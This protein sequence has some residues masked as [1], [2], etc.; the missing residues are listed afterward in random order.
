MEEK[1][2]GKN[3]L[4][5]AFVVLLVF[6]LGIGGYFVYTKI[7]AGNKKDKGESSEKSVDNKNYELKKFSEYSH[8]LTNM[9]VSY[10]N[11]Y[12]LFNG[13]NR[14]YG[15][16]AF[17]AIKDNVIVKDIN[18]DVR[19]FD[20]TDIYYSF[21]NTP[22]PLISELKFVD[23]KNDGLSTEIYGKLEHVKNEKFIAKKDDKYGLI[24]KYGKEILSFE[25]QYIDNEPTDRYN[26]NKNNSYLFVIKNNKSGIVDIDGKV[27]I[28]LEYDF[29]YNEWYG[30]K[31]Y[32]MNDEY[33]SIFETNGHYYFM[34]RKNNKY[35]VLDSNNNKILESDKKIEYIKNIDKLIIAN[36]NNNNKIK[37][38]EFYSFDGKLIKSINIEE[39]W[40][41]ENY[42]N[43][44]ILAENNNSD[45]F[46]IIRN[47]T[48][49]NK[50]YLLD[51][52][53]N[54]KEFD[55]LYYEE[56]YGE[57]GPFYRYFINDKFYLLKKDNKF[58]LYDYKTGKIIEN[59]YANAYYTGPY[60]TNPVIILCKDND[61][62]S[63]GILDLNGKF[64]TDF[65]YEYIK[66]EDSMVGSYLTNNNKYR[67]YL[68]FNDELT[69]DKT[70]DIN[71]LIP[72]YKMGK[73]YQTLDKKLYDNNCK[74]LTERNTRNVT[75]LNNGYSIVEIDNGIDDKYDYEIYDKNDN[76]ITY[77]NNDDAK[78][79]LF[80]GFANN[81]LF[82][83]MDKGIYSI[84]I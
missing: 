39:N 65:N 5:I 31:L 68:D 4:V 38:I 24:D 27:I 50:S 6:V 1:K 34:L 13:Y 21:N 51:Y 52:N 63:C 33:P 11:G 83:L 15:Q 17:T 66:T 43:N 29:I 44:Y 36:K 70:F 80:L 56:E 45:N 59:N 35:C 48:S 74:Q 78:F 62:K 60:I 81:K 47:K 71:T 57:G 58:E 7:Y 18:E 28:P 77:K 12:Y 32:S 82:F 8:D 40:D 26:M 76:I 61:N 19:D 55:N 10:N 9:S 16:H 75:T 64:I 22:D 72:G 46:I 67:L 2:K 54:I 42:Y 73:Y 53:L 25:Y 14:L 3:W 84:D 23:Y 79:K 49:N 37:N 30:Q 20:G 69:C 41:F